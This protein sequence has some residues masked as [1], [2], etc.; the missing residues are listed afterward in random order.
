VVGLVAVG[1]IAHS[2]A[3][4]AEGGDYLLDAPIP[5]VATECYRPTGD[6]GTNSEAKPKPRPHHRIEL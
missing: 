3:V 6:N 4:L 1:V 2:I 5:P